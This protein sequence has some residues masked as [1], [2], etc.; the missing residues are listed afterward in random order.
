VASDFG[1]P[2]PTHKIATPPFYAA[3]ASAALYCGG[4]SAGGFSHHG[5]TRAVFQSLIAWK[6][7]ATERKF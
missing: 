1:E 4:E 7:A 3:R 2:R 6:N 5:L